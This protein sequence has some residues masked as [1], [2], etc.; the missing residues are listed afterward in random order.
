M[1]TTDFKKKRPLAIFIGYFK[2]HKGLFFVDI[3][4]ACLIAAVD[5]AFPLI[6]R[7]ALYDMLPGKL[8]AT[9][10]TVVVILVVVAAVV[11]A[12]VVG[13]AVVSAGAVSVGAVA[14]LSSVATVVVSCEVTVVAAVVTVVAS[15]ESAGGVCG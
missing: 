4:C 14:V 12:S 10:F 2:N 9:F 6:T 5:L 11:G 15:D 7:S 1:Q 3:L 13:L 8:Y